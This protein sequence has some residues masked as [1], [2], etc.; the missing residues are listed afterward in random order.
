MPSPTTAL[1]KI[2]N[3][4]AFQPDGL[5]IQPALVPAAKDNQTI[6]IFI[7]YLTGFED[8]FPELQLADLAFKGRVLYPVQVAAAELEHRGGSR[9]REES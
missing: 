7:H 2:I 1:K 3:A 8:E 5:F 6:L 4:V 9:V